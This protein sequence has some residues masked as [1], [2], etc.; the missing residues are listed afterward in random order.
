MS[1]RKN[2]GGRPGVD[3]GKPGIQFLVI[4]PAGLKARLQRRAEALGV[5]AGELVRRYVSAGLDASASAAEAIQTRIEQGESIRMIRG[6]EEFR[7]RL[8][9]GLEWICEAW[10]DGQ[11]RGSR[12]LLQEHQLSAELEQKAAAGWRLAP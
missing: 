5:S 11:R 8:T 12:W 4:M 3:G 1:E 9:G 6:D 7:A 2:P 10:E